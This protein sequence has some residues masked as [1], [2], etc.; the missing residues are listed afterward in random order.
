[1][2]R[3]RMGR[4]ACLVA[5]KLTRLNPNVSQA[6]AMR[7]AWRAIKSS[8]CSVLTF[9]KKNGTVSV[10][11]IDEKIT[12]YYTPKGTGR[13]TDTFKFVDVA[14]YVHTGEGSRSVRSCNDYQVKTIK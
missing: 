2:Q 8:E 13:K 14:E 9:A 11:V 5:Q 4:M 10:R 1:M 7:R 3:Y 6:D 12:R